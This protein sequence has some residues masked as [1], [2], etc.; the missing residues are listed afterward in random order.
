MEGVSQL[1]S[2][3]LFY[4]LVCFFLSP[5]FA[6]YFSYSGKTFFSFMLT[7]ASTPVDLDGSTSDAMN[8]SWDWGQRQPLDHRCYWDWE[9]EMDRAYHPRPDPNPLT[10]NGE[11][12]QTRQGLFGLDS[13]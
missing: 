2:C 12:L 1:Q 11:K 6:I 13:M 9:A 8:R 10:F 3:F 7:C 5:K 4:L